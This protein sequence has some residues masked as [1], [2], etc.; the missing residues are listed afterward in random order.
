[1]SVKLNI[2]EL[3][4][5]KKTLPRG[6]KSKL[7]ESAGCSIQS[8]TNVFKDKCKDHEIICRVIDEAISLKNKRQKR[9]LQISKRVSEAV[10]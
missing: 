4:E 8:V 3:S 9:L 1:M 2:E 5:L 10:S 6:W 7:A